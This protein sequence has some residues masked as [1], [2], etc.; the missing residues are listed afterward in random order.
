[1]Q[2][3]SVL[4]MTAPTPL[5][6][7]FGA[8]A[9]FLPSSVAAVPP[10]PAE[11][12]QQLQRESTSGGRP[13]LRR[14]DTLHSTVLAAISDPERNYRLNMKAVNGELHTEEVLPGDAVAPSPMMTFDA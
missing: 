9:S 14:F 1:M 5:G 12:E 2:P 10:A 6:S 11:R 13:S 8:V 7:F 3:S 4:S